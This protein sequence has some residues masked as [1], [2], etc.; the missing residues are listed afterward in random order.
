M[1]EGRPAVQAEARNADDGEFECQYSPQGAPP[2]G[3]VVAVG[4]DEFAGVR[5]AADVEGLALYPTGRFAGQLLVS[6]QGDDTFHLYDRQGRNRYIG[7]FKINGTV[8]SDGVEVTSTALGRS[9]PQ[10]L[11]VVQ[12][13]AADDPAD[14]SAINGFEYDGSTQFRFVDW[15]TVD[16]TVIGRH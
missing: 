2:P 10:G 5:L 13:G 14:T 11:L 4:S 9:F 15:R 12:N 16:S 1:L 3:A 6:S 8:E 7:A